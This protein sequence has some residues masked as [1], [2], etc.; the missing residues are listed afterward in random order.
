MGIDE[1][2]PT[3]AI[4]THY[5]AFGIAP[6][7]CD[8]YLVTTGILSQKGIAVK[9]WLFRALPQKI[10]Q[11]VKNPGNQEIFSTDNLKLNTSSTFN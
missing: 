6:V 2:L 7:S 5:D 3:I 11:I 4:V 8:R 9:P 1:Q 10:V